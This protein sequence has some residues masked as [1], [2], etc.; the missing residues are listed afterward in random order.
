MK[1]TFEV[2]LKTFFLVSHMLSITL[3][4]QTSKDIVDTTINPSHPDLG[5]GEKINLRRT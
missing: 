1:R 5:R 4:K 3:K 2:N